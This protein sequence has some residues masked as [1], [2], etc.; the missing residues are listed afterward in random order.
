LI[1]PVVGAEN[2]VTQKGTTPQLLDLPDA[3]VVAP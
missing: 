2:T 1:A 3:L